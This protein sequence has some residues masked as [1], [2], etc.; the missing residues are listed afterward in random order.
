MTIHLDDEGREIPQP[1]S[2]TSPT[3][4]D[5]TTEVLEADMLDLYLCCQCSTYC[6]V[7]QVIPGVIPLRCL[8][9]FNKDKVEHPPPGKTGELALI[10]GWETV[11]TYVHDPYLCCA[12]QVN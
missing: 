7:S 10:T 2:P 5:E 3:P 9:E 1:A 11:L 4:A 6:L 8:E 12:N